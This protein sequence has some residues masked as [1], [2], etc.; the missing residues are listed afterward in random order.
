MFRVMLSGICL[1]ITGQ[2]LTVGTDNIFHQGLMSNECSDLVMSFTN[3]NLSI[4]IYLSP[5]LIG[6][7]CKYVTCV[8]SLGEQN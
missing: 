1:Y 2:K 7:V 6:Y 8:V 4:I 5:A 3:V